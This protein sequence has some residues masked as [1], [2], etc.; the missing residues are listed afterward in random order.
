MTSRA[1]PPGFVQFSGSAQLGYPEFRS[2]GVMASMG[3]IVEN[4]HIGLLLVDFVTDLIGLHVNGS[5]WLVTDA[6]MHAN[7]PDLPRDERPGHAATR[8]VLLDVREA[9]IHCRKHV[10]RMTPAPHTLD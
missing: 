9:D 6:Q 3:N 2:N 5:A 8:W 10:P 1:G 4:P 7:Y